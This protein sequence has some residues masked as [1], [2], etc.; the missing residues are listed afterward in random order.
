MKYR[1]LIENLEALRDKYRL[2][3]TGAHEA[4]NDERLPRALRDIHCACA[5]ERAMAIGYLDALIR[6]AGGNV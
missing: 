5:T 6:E 3:Y 2:L 1:T 4:K